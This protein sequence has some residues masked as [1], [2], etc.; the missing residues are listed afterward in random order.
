MTNAKLA[1]WSIITQSL[2]YVSVPLDFKPHDHDAAADA[3]KAGRPPGGS[4]WNFPGFQAPK[5]RG[6]ETRKTE[7]PKKWGLRPFGFTS[8]TRKASNT[9]KAVLQSFRAT[10][11]GSGS[12]YAGNGEGMPFLASRPVLFGAAAPLPAPIP[13]FQGFSALNFGFSKRKSKIKK[14]HS[15]G[16]SSQAGPGAT[17]DNRREVDQATM[18]VPGPWRPPCPGVV[19]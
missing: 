5:K 15:K 3:V 4:G 16:A 9:A 8:L 19:A 10:P 12:D 11:P 6:Q 2:A 13:P 18:R 7:P 1:P 17:G 14:I